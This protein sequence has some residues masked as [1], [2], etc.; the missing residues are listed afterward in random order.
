MKAEVKFWARAFMRSLRMGAMFARK[1]SF[2]LTVWAALAAV[3]LGFA[4]FF[5][6][7]VT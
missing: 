3:T 5:L 4:L 2:E 1:H 6:S 7:R